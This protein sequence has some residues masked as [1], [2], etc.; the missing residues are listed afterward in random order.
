MQFV[1]PEIISIIFWGSVLLSPLL[2]AIGVWQSSWKI[3]IV[4]TLGSLPYVLYV[5]LSP[6]G[7]IFLIVPVL[8][9]IEAAVSL[10][11]WS[12]RLAWLLLAIIIGFSLWF[13][14]VFWTTTRG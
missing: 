12:A 11:H 1:S 3:F 8:H 7:R 6:G 10:R 9:L 2:A 4:S 5:A 14:W 13:V